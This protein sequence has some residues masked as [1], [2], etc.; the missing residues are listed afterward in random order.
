MKFAFHVRNIAVKDHNALTEV[1]KA[2]VSRI[3]AQQ[4]AK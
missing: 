3:M 1:Q 2:L 4:T